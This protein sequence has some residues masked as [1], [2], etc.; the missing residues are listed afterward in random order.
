MKHL[1]IAFSMLCAVSFA[2][3]SAKANLKKEYCSNQTYYT[4]TGEND[5]GRYPHLHC[6][7]KFLTYSSGSTHYNFVIG[8]T[9][10]SGTAGSACFKAEEQD[11]PNLK[12]KIAEVC[13]DFGKACY[14]C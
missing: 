7:T 14:G 3:S 12:A 9:L 13:D 5:G 2:A 11:A 1:V 8:N 6:D 10:Q 4:E